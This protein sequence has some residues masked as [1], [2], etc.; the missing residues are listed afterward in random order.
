MLTKR[1]SPANDPT[2]AMGAV[3]EAAILCATAQ[4]PQTT[5]RDLWSALRRMLRGMARG[6][7]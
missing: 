6:A 3:M 4:D 2:S 5:A 7:R 1:V